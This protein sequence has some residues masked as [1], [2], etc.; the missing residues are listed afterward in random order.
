MHTSIYGGSCGLLMAWLAMQTIK[1]RHAKLAMPTLKF[2]AQF[3]Q[4]SRSACG[5]YCVF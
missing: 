1:A 5:T 4:A 2:A 3:G